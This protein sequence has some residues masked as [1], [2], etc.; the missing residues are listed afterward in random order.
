MAVV[1]VQPILIMTA[2][3]ICISQATRYPAN[4]TSNKGNFTFE[5]ATQ[6]AGVATK[7][8]A[9]VLPLQI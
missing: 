7:F 6:K 1:F 8:W 4:Y 5:D 2:S 3:R 9:T